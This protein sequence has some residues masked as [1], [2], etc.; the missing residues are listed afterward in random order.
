MRPEMLRETSRPSSATARATIRVPRAM[1]R[2]IAL[3]LAVDLGER[4]GGADHRRHLVVGVEDRD[5]HVEHAHL[6]RLAVTRHVDRC[7][8]LR[9]VCTSGAIGGV[10]VGHGGRI[11]FGVG[12]HLAFRR[13]RAVG[14]GDHREPGV[15]GGAERLDERLELGGLVEQRRRSGC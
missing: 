2:V 8:P 7:S 11:G 15:G 9:A 5:G 12:Q 4:Q 3:Q 14:P 6:E 10:V 13:R 1:R